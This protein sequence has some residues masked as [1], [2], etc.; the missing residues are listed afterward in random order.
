MQGR[1]T[2]RHEELLASCYR[3]CLELAE[4]NRLRSVAFCCI[5]TGVFGFPQGR[6]A[7]IAVQTVRKFKTSTHSEIEVIFNVFKDEDY[8]IYRA[9]L[10]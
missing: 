5:S 4:E 10:G 1:L 6:A 2:K 9:L 3:A 8:A 7:E